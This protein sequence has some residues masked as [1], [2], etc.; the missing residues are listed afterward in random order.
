M[1]I[2]QVQFPVVGGCAQRAADSSRA[3]EHQQQAEDR[4]S[5][6][7]KGLDRVGPDD[8]LDAA[9]CRVENAQ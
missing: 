3:G 2:G 8:R 1:Q 6:E 7:H 5:E 9:H 4:S